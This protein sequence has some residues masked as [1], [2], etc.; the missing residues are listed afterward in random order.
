MRYCIY[1]GAEIPQ[2]A[3][4]CQICGKAQ[5]DVVAP[6]GEE[7]A[8]QETGRPAWKKKFAG[9]LA[10]P[11]KLALLTAGAFVLLLCLFTG[12]FLLVL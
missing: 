2:S 5:P 12:I 7:D 11:K 6:V 10:S 4:Y 8:E 9:A 1:C 3:A